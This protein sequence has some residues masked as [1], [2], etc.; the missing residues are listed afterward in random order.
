MISLFGPLVSVCYASV[1]MHSE[2][3][4]SHFVCVRV[5]DGSE[6]IY[7]FS[8]TLGKG[9]CFHGYNTVFLSLKFAD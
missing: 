1:C 6:R 7:F 8:W 5:C 4:G 9:K 2:A 3:Y